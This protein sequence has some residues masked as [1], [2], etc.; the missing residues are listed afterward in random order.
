MTTPTGIFTPEAAAYGYPKSPML[1][2]KLSQIFDKVRIIDIG[3]GDCFYINHLSSPYM[4]RPKHCLGVDGYFPP[5]SGSLRNRGSFSLFLKDLTQ[6][7]DL[8]DQHGQ[9]LCL[10]VGEHIPEQFEQVF[11]DNLC[12]NCNSRMVLSWAIPGQGGIGHVN[13]RPNQWVI[14]EIEKRGFKF[15]IYLTHYLR[16][17]IE[18]GVKYFENTLMVFDK[19]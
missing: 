19:Q 6:P 12:N 3:A 9:V 11:I 18:R 7:F 15:N 5:E 1:L 17:D 14:A 8:I 13:C 10:E 16:T 2:F 4:H